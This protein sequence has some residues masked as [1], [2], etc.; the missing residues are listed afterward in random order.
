MALIIASIILTGISGGFPPVGARSSD[1]Q[2]TSPA[3]Q[4]VALHIKGPITPIMAEYV[5]GGI[6][7]ANRENATLDRK[8]VV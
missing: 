3:T 1:S 2:S 7:Q 8:S 4:V 6:D 5:D